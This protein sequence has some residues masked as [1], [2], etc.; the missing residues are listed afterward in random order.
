MR[1]AIQRATGNHHHA[2]L[3]P[4]SAAA[5]RF[6]R[7]S[8]LPAAR[9][10]AAALCLSRRRA[11][12]GGEGD[13]RLLPAHFSE[14]KPRRDVA[15]GGVDFRSGGA[16]VFAAAGVQ[17]DLR[18]YARAGEV[19]AAGVAVGRALPG[20][21][22]VS[23]RRSRLRLS[24]AK[25]R[26]RTI[27]ASPIRTWIRTRRRGIL[28]GEVQRYRPAKAEP[29]R[30]LTVILDGE[31]AWEWYTQDMDGKRFLHNLYA[32]LTAAR[33]AGRINLRDADGVLRGQSRTQDSGASG[34]QSR[35]E[36]QSCGRVRGSTPTSTRGSA[37]RKRTGRGS[38]C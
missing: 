1:S 38:I 15:G 14:A 13:P 33:E 17:L 2:V 30:L 5:D 35:R 23:T 27:S 4:D 16:A 7:G 6:G 11:G 8:S 25:R 19:H 18:R 3:S 32:G 37:S 31:N 20:R 10:A 24:S 9:F 22:A 29:D 34:R 21:Y 26:S 28:S 12:A 36:S